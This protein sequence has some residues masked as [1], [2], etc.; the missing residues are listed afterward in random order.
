MAQ[1][2]TKPVGAVETTFE[3]LDALKTCNGAGVTELAAHLDIPKST[4]H[5]HLTT[6]EQLGYATREGDVYHVGLQF[7]DLGGFAREQMKVYRTA[8]PHVEELAE[9]T[10][11]W[12]NLCVPDHDRAVYLQLERGAR[13]VELDV[14]VGMRVYPHS[15]ALGK[16]IL[17]Y[18]DP[19]AVHALVERHGLPAFSERTVTDESELFE[20]LEAIRER[21]YAYDREER[22]QGLRCVAAPIIQGEDRV[23]GG[24]S[25][26]GP[27]SRMKGER[28]EVELPELVT[29]AANVISINLTYS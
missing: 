23:V 11:E 2:R 24:V 22:L 6:L 17:A 12:A 29:S 27:V 7:L 5:S 26:S 14:Y 28:F 1:Q 4:A 16:V 21:G 9:K 18:R 25:V 3:V 8:R 15:T 13:A 19:S 20:Q 10:G